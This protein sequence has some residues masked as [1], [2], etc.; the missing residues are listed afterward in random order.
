[1]DA[2]ELFPESQYLKSDDVEAVGEMLLTIKSIVPKIYTDETT[3]KEERKGDLSFVEEKKK[4]AT[5]VTNNR[6]LVA[7]FGKTDIEKNW[8][9]KQITLYVD[10]NIPYGN[11]IVSGIRIRNIDPKQDAIT[12]FWT[13]AH[14][15]GLTNIEGQ[16]IV[17]ENG[18]DFAKALAALD[19]P[20]K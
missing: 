20:F 3:G 16:A 17:K 4:L 15:M 5:N 13:E 14:K 6:T 12:A 2:N 1:M 9:G 19:S 7:M 11:K 8:V 10:H 18:G